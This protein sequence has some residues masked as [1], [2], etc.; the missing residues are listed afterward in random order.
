[1]LNELLPNIP[2]REIE[3]AH[4]HRGVARD[5]LRERSAERHRRG[6]EESFAESAEIG[7]PPGGRGKKRRRDQDR[8]RGR[9]INQHRPLQGFPL[10]G[11]VS[12]SSSVAAKAAR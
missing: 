8:G 3:R 7:D 4:P 12:F 6:T 5:H 9:E 11:A 2:E 1:M 10:R